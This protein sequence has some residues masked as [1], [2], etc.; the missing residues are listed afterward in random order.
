MVKVTARGNNQLAQGVEEDDDGLWGGV[1]ND[2]PEATDNSKPR[3]PLKNFFT[4]SGFAQRLKSLL[5]GK[6]PQSQ[7]EMVPQQAVETHIHRL[8]Q[9]D[10]RQAV[11]NFLGKFKTHLGN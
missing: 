2:T 3:L 11:S 6:D 7:Q 1:T 5:K 8:I 9:G 4:N 10:Y